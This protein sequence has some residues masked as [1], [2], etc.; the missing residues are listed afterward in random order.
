MITLIGAADLNNAIGFENKLLC[1]L[2]DDMRHFVNQTKGKPVIMGYTTFASLGFKPLK[3]RFNIVLT[4]SP[5]AMTAQH[6]DVLEQHENLVFESLDYIL[7]M[8]EQSPEKEFMVIGG[9]KTY[10]LFLPLASRIYLTS[11]FYCFNQ[12]DTYFPDLD[13]KEWTPKII[14]RVPSDAR[15]DH[16]FIIMK[17][18][19]K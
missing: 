10:E 11:I 19:R 9:Q 16:P 3:G 4:N 7:F 5:L 13:L 14:E 15:N 2:K 6:F 8:V 12:A 1:T 17:Y 18:E